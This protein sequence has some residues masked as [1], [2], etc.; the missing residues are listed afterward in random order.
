MRATAVRARLPWAAINATE[1]L[2]PLACT[3]LSGLSPRGDLWAVVGGRVRRWRSAVEGEE[4]RH[5]GL[6]SQAPHVLNV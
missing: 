5:G 4:W 2:T 1:L 6:V 3:V